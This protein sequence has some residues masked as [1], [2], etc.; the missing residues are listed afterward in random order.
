MASLSQRK[1]AGVFPD[2]RPAW[3]AEGEGGGR[4]RAR[5]DG[6]THEGSCQA[7]STMCKQAPAGT[8]SSLPP[9]RLGGGTSPKRRR[10]NTGNFFG[11]AKYLSAV[12]YIYCH[13]IRRREG[14][15]AARGL[16]PRLQQEE[17]ESSPGPRAG[18]VPANSPP[19][20]SRGRPGV[21]GK[22]AGQGSDGRTQFL[23]P[24]AVSLFGMMDLR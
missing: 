21:P 7:A 16:E 6:R 4:G 24:A 23:A 11:T 22:A 8:R 18:Q 15:G 10:K 2:R 3:H 20:A 9:G 19:A 14:D 1:G 12:I 5:T 13:Q 17:D